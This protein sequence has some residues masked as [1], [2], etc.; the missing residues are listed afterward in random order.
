[1][2]TGV[3]VWVDV[4]VVTRWLGMTVLVTDFVVVPDAI[5]MQE[6]ADE[7]ALAS[8]VWRHE[9]AAAVVVAEET[10]ESDVTARF[11]TTALSEVVVTGIQVSVAVSFVLVV[12][13]S[14]STTV[15][16][17][18]KASVDIDVTVSTN[19]LTEA[20]LV[21]YLVTVVLPDEAVVVATTFLTTAGVIAR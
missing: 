16:V 8:R 4:W 1:M 18:V 20:V 19:W 11:P 14:V 13:Y 12:T 3:M 21:T 9:G 15:H 17:S 5:V 10:L 2:T 6:H 7:I